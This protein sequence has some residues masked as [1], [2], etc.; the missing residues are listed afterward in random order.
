MMPFQDFNAHIFQTRFSAMQ[1]TA[2]NNQ[3]RPSGLRFAYQRRDFAAYAGNARHFKFSGMVERHGCVVGQL[4]HIGTSGTRINSGKLIA[5]RHFLF[6]PVAVFIFMC[7]SMAS[8]SGA[9][10]VVCGYSGCTCFLFSDG[11]GLSIYILKGIITQ[12]N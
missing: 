12:Y 8:L 1:M 9:S 6:P 3:H 5:V 7:P 4:R 11:H 10:C 2:V